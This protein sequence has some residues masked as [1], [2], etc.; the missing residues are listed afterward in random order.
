M[1][2]F[3][4]NFFLLF[5]VLFLSDS[6]KG[7]NPLQRNI[8]SSIVVRPGITVRSSSEGVGRTFD[9]GVKDTN[10]ILEQYYDGTDQ[11][12]RYNIATQDLKGQLVNKETPSSELE[13]EGGKE[14]G[15]QG[16]HDE[17]RDS[18]TSAVAQ[19]P[20]DYKFPEAV[21][22]LT[23]DKIPPLSSGPGFKDEFEEKPNEN[24]GGGSEDMSE[25][26]TEIMS[27]SEGLNEGTEY[28]FG[29]GSEGFGPSDIGYEAVDEP[30]DQGMESYSYQDVGSEAVNDSYRFESHQEEDPGMSYV[31]G[32][33]DTGR[34]EGSEYKY[35]DESERSEGYPERESRYIEDSETANSET[36]KYIS[37]SS[38]RSELEEGFSAESERSPGSEEY[39]S[40][41]EPNTEYEYTSEGEDK[42]GPESERVKKKRRNRISKIPNL[43]KKWD[44][45]TEEEQQEWLDRHPRH[46]SGSEELDQE[47]A[48]IARNSRRPRRRDE[49]DPIDKKSNLLNRRRR[50]SP[51]D[52]FDSPEDMAYRGRRRRRR[53]TRGEVPED[54]STLSIVKRRRG[55]RNVELEEPAGMKNRR[56]R[57][58]YDFIQ[59][60][61]GDPYLTTV[62]ERVLSKYPVHKRENILKLRENALRDI[63]SGRRPVRTFEDLIDPVDLMLIY[64]DAGRMP[65]LTINDEG[66]IPP[67]Y[68]LKLPKGL[69]RW[70]ELTPKERSR[71]KRRWRDEIV[72]GTFWDDDKLHGDWSEEVRLLGEW[73]EEEAIRG[74][75]GKETGLE[76]QMIEDHSFYNFEPKFTDLKNRG[77]FSVEYPEDIE[78]LILVGDILP[79][80]M[81]QG[82]FRAPET[83]LLKF[84]PRFGEFDELDDGFTLENVHSRRNEGSYY[85]PSHTPTW[86]ESRTRGKFGKDRFPSNKFSWI[87]SLNKDDALKLVEEANYGDPDF[88]KKLLLKYPWLRDRIGESVYSDDGLILPIQVLNEFIPGSISKLAKED[89]RFPGS[90]W[91][92]SEI[93]SDQNLDRY[94]T[95]IY[96]QIGPAGRLRYAPKVSSLPY[97]LNPIEDELS[98]DGWDRETLNY[99]RE[100]FRDAENREMELQ[101]ELNG[102]SLPDGK[103]GPSRLLGRNRRRRHKLR[104]SR[105]DM[106]IWYFGTEEQRDREKRLEFAI[107][108]DSMGGIVE[109]K[110]SI[111]RVFLDP[112]GRKVT[113]N[114]LDLELQ[115]IS[116]EPGYDVES[117]DTNVEDEDDDYFNLE[118]VGSYPSS[119]YIPEYYQSRSQNEQSGIYPNRG[120]KKFSRRGSESFY[121]SYQPRKRYIFGDDDIDYLSP[122]SISQSELLQEAS[123]FNLGN[124]FLGNRKWNNASLGRAG[125]PDKPGRRGKMNLNKRHPRAHRVNEFGQEDPMEILKDYYDSNESSILDVFDGKGIY[126]PLKR[127]KVG[128]GVGD[129]DYLRR[130][131]DDDWNYLKKLKEPKSLGSKGNR[132]EKPL[133]YYYDSIGRRWDDSLEDDEDLLDSSIDLIIK[134]ITSKRNRKRGSHPK[135]ERPNDNDPTEKR[136][137]HRKKEDSKK[138]LTDKLFGKKIKAR[139]KS[140]KEKNGRPKQVHFN[141]QNDESESSEESLDIA[142]DESSSASTVDSEADSEN[143]E[144][145]EDLGPLA[146]RLLMGAGYDDDLDPKK[147]LSIE[148]EILDLIDLGKK[149]QRTKRKHGK[150]DKSE[151]KKDTQLTL[152]EML[153][154]IGKIKLDPHDISEIRRLRR[155]L[156]DDSG[157][158]EALKSLI[159]KLQLD[160]YVDLTDERGSEMNGSETSTY[161]LDNDFSASSNENNENKSED[162]QSSEG[163]DEKIANIKPVQVIKVKRN[164]KDLEKGSSGNSLSSSLE[165][166][167]SEMS[168]A[169]EE[170]FSM[171]EWDSFIE[172]EL[173]KLVSKQKPRR[174]KGSGKSPQSHPK[175]KRGLKK[176]KEDKEAL[177]K[178]GVSPKVIKRINSLLKDRENGIKDALDYLLDELEN[179]IE[180]TLEEP[181]GEKNL[182]KK[183]KKKKRGK[184]ANRHPYDLEPVTPGFSRYILKLKDVLGPKDALEELLDNLGVDL[185]ESQP[186]PKE[187]RRYLTPSVLAEVRSLKNKKNGDEQAL[188]K[189]MNVLRI[190]NTRRK[191]VKRPKQAKSRSRDLPAL[192]S[193]EDIKTVNRLLKRN[194]APQALN[195]FI[196]STDLDKD[197]EDYKN[198]SYNPRRSYSGLGMSPEN[199]SKIVHLMDQDSQGCRD[200]LSE[201]YTTLGIPKQKNLFQVG[202][203]N[204]DSLDP[205][206]RRSPRKN[207]QRRMASLP[208]LQ[209]YESN[210]VEE[211]GSEEEELSEFDDFSTFVP[212]NYYKLRNTGG[213]VTDPNKIFPI[214]ETGPRYYGSQID[215]T[216]APSLGMGHS[217]SLI[218][219]PFRNMRYPSPRYS[220]APEMSDYDKDLRNYVNSRRNSFGMPGVPDYHYWSYEPEIT[221]RS[222]Y[223]GLETPSNIRRKRILE[224][225]RKL[226]NYLDEEHTVPVLEDYDDSDSE[227]GGF[228]V[229][230]K[231]KSPKMVMVKSYVDDD[232]PESSEELLL[233][234]KP[235][236]S[237]EEL[238]DLGQKL[239]KPPKN[240]NTGEKLR[241]GDSDRNLEGLDGFEVERE[242]TREEILSTLVTDPKI[243]LESRKV[244]LKDVSDDEEAVFN[245]LRNMIVDTP[246]LERTSIPPSIETA[247]ELKERK[248]QVPESKEITSY[249][250]V[251]ASMSEYDKKLYSNSFVESLE[252]GGYEASSVSVSSQMLKDCSEIANQLKMK[253]LGCEKIQNN[254]TLKGKFHPLD[255]RKFSKRVSKVKNQYAKSFLKQIGFSGEIAKLYLESFPVLKGWNK[256]MDKHRWV[257]LPLVSP[258]SYVPNL[259]GLNILQKMILFQTTKRHK[260]HSPRRVLILA[261]SSNSVSEKKLPNSLANLEASLKNSAP[262]EYTINVD[263]KQGMLIIPLVELA[264]C[265]KGGLQ[266][267]NSKSKSKKT[268]M[269]TCIVGGVR[270]HSAAQRIYRTA[271]KFLEMSPDLSMAKFMIIPVR[272][273]RESLNEQLSLSESRSTEKNF[274]IQ[275]PEDAI[276]PAISDLEF[277]K[278]QF[279]M[280]FEN[281][282]QVKERYNNKLMKLSESIFKLYLKTSREL[283][284]R[285]LKANGP[286][287]IVIP[288]SFPQLYIKGYSRALKLVKRIQNRYRP[289]LRNRSYRNKLKPGFI[290]LINDETTGNNSNTNSFLQSQI[291]RIQSFFTNPYSFRNFKS[292]KHEGP[293]LE[294][295]GVNSLQIRKSLLDAIA[296]ASRQPSVVPMII[297]PIFVDNNLK[298]SRSDKRALKKTLKKNIKHSNNI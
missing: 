226:N 239:S 190:P 236:Y 53:P 41:K 247:E 70:E 155:D 243:D 149:S 21:I 282:K 285:S 67:E 237:E 45:F 50:G 152:D 71:L 61:S 133:W 182:S 122:L 259:G 4:Q 105:P 233:V 8:D 6:V 54:S 51:K 200:A 218:S 110:P 245:K 185:S 284:L 103:G 184:R 251:D 15:V 102:Y 150:G 131:N 124:P 59:S 141:L 267:R 12:R 81:L 69:Y 89:D 280:Q 187:L 228:S 223:E 265:V 202:R 116:E 268:I 203:E 77:A 162:I 132:K 23:K 178:L 201:I 142:N 92:Y 27:A 144:D 130:S 198:G 30:L 7:N 106:P 42:D 286:R 277:S 208:R 248:S 167:S 160:D 274:D 278:L 290:L 117:Y 262:V 266:L 181:S 31:I 205:Q 227:S 87:E 217:N 158:L 143:E 168:Q 3:F 297:L 19:T 156:D 28:N 84:H 272:V 76:G 260:R 99:L 78:H 36:L 170:E 220:Y 38:H 250:Y 111:R 163:V 195:Y 72:N 147:P 194:K 271:L 96:E 68:L 37:E 224:R 136:R 254:E 180:T 100:L 60:I 66:D 57:R 65:I 204:L 129:L 238:Y 80:E 107:E 292:P 287:S 216:L 123:G 101:E 109:R 270:S 174:K 52:T 191:G 153:D 246:M 128:F 32:D 173:K 151:N 291:K 56:R 207:R 255:I 258:Q 289:S 2:Y 75:L 235:E 62:G 186:V 26:Q 48:I 64:R 25:E 46:V 275:I 229:L 210:Y 169:E 189:L 176:S 82:D 281:S 214:G 126:R 269:G 127:K 231:E 63:S 148:T 206:F 219:P 234:Q 240:I 230:K 10:A 112:N 1:Q 17:Q 161:T 108:S 171:S 88:N 165:G 157:D 146:R 83:Q 33:E 14:N 296:R 263:Y 209:D 256:A 249:G 40:D 283:D 193:E 145:L 55:R 49:L 179:N 279:E 29:G 257:A 244:I 18:E 115:D 172:D 225:K 95:D 120:S 90:R 134:E 276:S 118:M 125:K 183:R 293:V 73:G 215:S 13:D 121:P 139:R 221:G 22:P 43:P 97:L 135:N 273:G 295:R 93:P 241:L 91:Y 298:T 9:K 5:L 159:K 137:S 212:R 113:E 104:S 39:I 20:V 211:D 232:L 34:S 86:L 253:E 24:R 188:K 58:G 16:P 242:A 166:S 47:G 44:E 74:I 164:Q 197:I 199:L 264:L 94:I 98:L 85:Y 138:K 222:V 252:N 140:K 192:L 177:M 213:Y 175:K 154:S 114:V 196:K 261:F 79:E 294:I 11:W 119:K 35:R 288:M